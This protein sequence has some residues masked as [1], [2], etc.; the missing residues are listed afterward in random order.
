MTREL[1]RAYAACEAIARSHDE[2][3]PIGS[4]LLPRTE[5]RHLAALYAYARGADD[6]ADEPFRGDREAALAAWEHRLDDA[7][8]GR[9]APPVFRAVAHTIAERGLGAEPLRALLRA[10]RRD[11]A[12]EP[13]A[14]FASLH[15]Y[16][17]D[18]ANPVGRVVLG[19][20]GVRD[21]AAFALSD[22]V[23]TGLQLANFC[24]DLSVDLAR[25]RS[26]LP[27]DE[28][29]AHEGAGLAI[30]QRATNPGFEALLERQIG[31][32]RAFL[33]AGEP[34]A[35]RLPFRAA[36]EVRAFAGG[37]L[38]ILDRVEALG[39]HILTERPTLAR[40]ELGTLVATSLGRTLRSHWRSPAG[41]TTRSARMRPKGTA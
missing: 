19:L 37:G 3:F 23:C 32:A 20:F 36:V 29:A 27:L 38:R 7:L 10:F 13:F 26:Y 1:E 8:A 39:G 31:R 34:L 24:Q 17:G 14:D 16:C 40:R 9:E 5:R 35:L 25:G 22:D 15:A 11:A 18:S 2:N 12:F 4:R 28:V 6:L 30:G 41:T 21:P 33:A